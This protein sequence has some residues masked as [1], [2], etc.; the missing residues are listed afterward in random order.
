[1]IE[2]FPEMTEETNNFWKYWMQ[3]LL[4]QFAYEEV[5]RVDAYGMRHKHNKEL[6]N[7][8]ER[9][10]LALLLRRRNARV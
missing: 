1:M 6:K 5:H 9:A 7:N 3:T 4:M 8:I 2:T 10:L